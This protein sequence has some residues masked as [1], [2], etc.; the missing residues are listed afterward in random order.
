MNYD[1]PT[2]QDINDYCTEYANEIRAKEEEFIRTLQASVKANEISLVFARE[3]LA[4]TRIFNS[5]LL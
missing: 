4:R 3:C 2:Q 1:N 5:N